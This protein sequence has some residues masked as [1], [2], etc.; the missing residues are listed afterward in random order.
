MSRRQLLCSMSAQELHDWQILEQID[1]FGQAREDARFAL[2]SAVV[3]N[4]AGATKQGGGKYE[5]QDFMLR[6]EDEQQKEGADKP[7]QTPEQIE[8]MFRAFVKANNAFWAKKT[9]TEQK[10]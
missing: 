7:Q 1:P 5:V 2:L 4:S 10:H 6:F 8:G 3:A 9:G